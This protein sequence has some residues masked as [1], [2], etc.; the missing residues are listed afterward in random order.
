EFAGTPLLSALRSAISSDPVSLYALVDGAQAFDLAFAARLMGH[1]IYTLFSGDLATT[2]ANVGP[3]L[4]QLADA[5]AFLERLAH[6]HGA[7]AGVLF[8]SSADVAALCRHLR[9]V[10]VV[11][12]EEGQEYFFRFYDP[13][14]LR[15]FL[16]TCREDDLQEFFGPIGRWIV[17]SEDGPSFVTYTIDSAPPI[18]LKRAVYSPPA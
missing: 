2:V 13:R 9:H 7:N 10:F 6:Q 8:Q 12:D 4:V 5:S 11:T 18:R 17:E 14:V 1:P 15:T 3:C 16:P